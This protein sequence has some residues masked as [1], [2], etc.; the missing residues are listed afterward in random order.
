[1][2][3]PDR[4]D[5]MT[6]RFKKTAIGAAALAVCALLG[7]TIALGAASK[8]KAAKTTTGTTSASQPKVAVFQ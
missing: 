2:T 8:P 4:K 1:M 3:A 7:A 5:S 6:H